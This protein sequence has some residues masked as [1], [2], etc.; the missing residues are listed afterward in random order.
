MHKFLTRFLVI[1]YCIALPFQVGCVGLQRANSDGESTDKAEMREQAM[2]KSKIG[3]MPR[4]SGLDRRARDI[5][6]SLGIK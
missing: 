5:E 1:V 2:L 6:S 3:S 4:G